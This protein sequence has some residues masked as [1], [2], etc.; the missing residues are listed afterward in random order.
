LSQEKIE[1]LSWLIA[2]VI[3][4]LVAF[5]IFFV[6]CFVAQVFDTAIEVSIFYIPAIV[7]LIIFLKRKLQKP[8]H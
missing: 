2:T 7:L 6:Q 1:S 5:T 3:M 8:S 4:A